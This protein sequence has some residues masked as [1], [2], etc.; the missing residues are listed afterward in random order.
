MTALTPTAFR[1]VDRLATVL[2]VEHRFSSGSGD[3]ASD[4]NG[5]LGNVLSDQNNSAAMVAHRAQLQASLG[6]NVPLNEADIFAYYQTLLSAS[7]ATIWGANL[8]EW[9]RSD[10][11]SSPTAFPDQS[12]NAL[13]YTGACT[14]TASDATLNNLPTISTDGVSQTMTSAINLPRPTTRP[15]TELVVAK[16]GAFST[17]GYLL[18]SGGLNFMAMGPFSAQQA[19]FRNGAAFQFIP[20]A[21]TDFTFP[22]NWC[23][24]SGVWSIKPTDKRSAGTFQRVGASVD[25]TA[26]TSGRVMGY[27]GQQV[28]W[29]EIVHLGIAATDRDLWIYKGYLDALTSGAILHT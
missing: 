14:Q 23:L 21:A 29:F 6:S 1:V 9:C 8:L 19:R 26:G 17:A 3:A 28:Q 15:T 13:G 22:G 16:L 7:P 18:D 5:W 10:L 27:T 20:A 24:W 4:V 11:G 12:G 25:D 2:G